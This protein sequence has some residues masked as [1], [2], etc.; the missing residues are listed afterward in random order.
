MSDR[1]PIKGRLFLLLSDRQDADHLARDL[2]AK[3]WSCAVEC[4]EH[5]LVVT[6]I[7]DC[8]PVAA[9][10]DVSKA[11]NRGIAVAAAVRSNPTTHAMPIVFIGASKVLDQV[12]ATVPDAIFA[13]RGALDYLLGELASR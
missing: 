5:D 2:D 11:S 8:R 13:S 6:Q 1:S 12:K 7:Q 3:G 4:E 9:I 10:I